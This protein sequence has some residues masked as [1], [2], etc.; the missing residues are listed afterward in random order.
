MNEKTL[1]VGLVA[2]F[3]LIAALITRNGDIAWMI[4]PFLAFLMAGILQTPDVE[5][6]S[7]LAK[8]SWEQT[9][10]N[11]I[12]SI[13]VKLVVQNKSLEAVH[14]FMEETVQPGMKITEGALNQWVTLRPGETTELKYAFTAA[15]GN[16]SWKSIRTKV[17]DPL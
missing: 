17:S 13:V 14:L 6:V 16:F 15:R 5:R 12:V 7:L 1:T 8:R 11:G 3:L 10:T 4:L 2:V 9:R